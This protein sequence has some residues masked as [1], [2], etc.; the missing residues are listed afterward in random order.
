MLS[1]ARHLRLFASHSL[2]DHDAMLCAA[3]PHVT[4]VVSAPCLV[5]WVPPSDPMQRLELVIDSCKDVDT[6]MANMPQAIRIAAKA[7]MGA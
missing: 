1:Y 5:R 3:P 7:S 4:D 6:I 2:P